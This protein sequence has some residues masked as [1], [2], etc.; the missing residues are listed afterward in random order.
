[1]CIFWLRDHAPNQLS[2]DT[3]QSYA[4]SEMP[5]T[6]SPEENGCP[7]FMPLVHEGALIGWSLAGV[8]PKLHVPSLTFW[9]I[10]FSSLGRSIQFD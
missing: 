8:N 3:S 1:M 7:W 4:L 9:L 10:I 5:L 2:T 6:Y